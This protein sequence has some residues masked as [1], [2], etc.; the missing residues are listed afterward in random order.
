MP[1]R[2]ATPKTVGTPNKAATSK[3]AGTAEAAG[4][5]KATGTAKAPR[6][7]QRAGARIKAVKGEITS[8]EGIAALSLDAL[9]SVAYGPEAMLVVLATAGAGALA[10]IEPITLVIVVLLVI[11]VLS[12]RQVI[13]AYPDGGGCYA[14]SK[15]NLGPRASHLAGASLIVDYTLTVAVSIAAGVAALVSAFPSLAPHSL[16][17][18]LAVLGLLTAVNLRGI[19]ASAKAFLLPTAIFVLGIYVVIVS[20]VVRSHAAADAGFHPAIIPKAAATVGILL[21]LKAFAAG[22]SALTGVEAIANDVPVFREPRAQRAM[23]TEVMLGGLLGTMLLGLAFLTVRFHIA[24]SSNQTVLSQITAASVGRGPIYYVVDLATTLILA[25]AANTSFGGFPVLVSLLARDNLVPHVFGLRGDRPVFRYGV[26]ILA[27]FAGVLLVAVGA[28]TESLIPLYAIGVFTGFTLSQGGLV[29]HW[30]KQRP[31]RWWSRAGLNGTGAVMTGVATVIFLVTKFTSGAW[32]VVIAIPALIL[33]FSRIERYYNHV[34]SA[35]GLGK[36]PG[37]PRGGKGIVIVP[38]AKLSRMTEFA[39]ETALS[40]SDEVVAVSV[41]FDREM[42]ADLKAAWE[43]W[44]PGV[45]LDI[46]H[47]PNRSFTEPI[48]E[49][50]ERPKIRECHQVLVLIPELEPSKWRHRV[51][52]NQRDIILANVLRRK[53]EVIVARLPFRLS[54]D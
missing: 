17:I 52:Q 12:Y 14:V 4:T 13:E 3:A 46:V 24:P 32:V 26:V 49:Y 40:L 5:T 28:N 22:C 33:L 48:L 51:L 37:R 53:T 34:A 38:V 45:E 50:L 7:R 23:R 8:L 9:S 16:L 27:V 19:A 11:L 18:S 10:K 1:G 35:L 20:G 2:A 47:S 43:R 21:L 15:A 42:A 44:N 25:L 41:Q 29:K 39:L 30:W 54:G 31:P 36:M 6:A